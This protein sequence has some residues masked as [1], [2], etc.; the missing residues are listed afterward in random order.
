MLVL[1]EIKL[2][3]SAQN[4]YCSCHTFG[5]SKD[6]Q[7]M[8]SRKEWL[9]AGRAGSASVCGTVR[10]WRGLAGGELGG[11]VEPLTRWPLQGMR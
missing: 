9:L 8:G 5:E 2:N 1:A 6:V 10:P 11:E 7:G 4:L 3:G